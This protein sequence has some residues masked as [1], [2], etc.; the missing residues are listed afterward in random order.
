MHCCKH[1]AIALS[2][3]KFIHA[4]ERVH[5]QQNNNDILPAGGVSANKVT[6]QLAVIFKSS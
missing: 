6:L 1:D 2:S 5:A 4:T 3:T